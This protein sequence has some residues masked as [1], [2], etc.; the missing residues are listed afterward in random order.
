MANVLL[1][2]LAQVV[3]A[4]A[5]AVALTTTEIHAKTVSIQAK[6]AASD[7]TGNVF[8]GPTGLTRGT[9]EGIELEPGDEYTLPIPAGDFIDLRS[10][11]VDADTAA[12]GVVVLYTI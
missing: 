7:N 9:V 1:K 2:R 8:I 12:D 11:Y 6:K 10:I 3:A 4:P 5:T